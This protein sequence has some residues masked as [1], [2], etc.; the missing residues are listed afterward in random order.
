MHSG[1]ILDEARKIIYDLNLW[2]VS[3]MTWI[4]AAEKVEQTY[5]RQLLSQA[6][7]LLSFWLHYQN[8]KFTDCIYSVDLP[9]GA[10]RIF[11]EYA[12][13]RIRYTASLPWTDLFTENKHISHSRKASIRG[14]LKRLVQIDQIDR[15]F[16]HFD[17][18]HSSKWFCICFFVVWLLTKSVGI[19]FYQLQYL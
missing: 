9:I 5:Q 8:E 17:H 19:E 13:S 15:S 11:A 3:T 7:A 2:L 18:Y 4:R 10:L 12:L 1:C 14:V 16:S 6:K